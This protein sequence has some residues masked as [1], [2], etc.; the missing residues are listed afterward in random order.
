VTAVIGYLGLVSWRAGRP[1]LTAL[2]AL[3]I[4]GIGPARLVTGVHLV[5]DVVAGYCVGASWLILAYTF[6]KPRT[7]GPVGESGDSAQ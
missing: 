1:W 6:S 2:A 4:V 7:V 3:L 5:S